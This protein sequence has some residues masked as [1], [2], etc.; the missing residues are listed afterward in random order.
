MTTRKAQKIEDLV[1]DEISL[2]DKGANQHAVVTI[3]K[4]A[5][6]EMEEAMEIYDEQ[7]NPLDL[8]AL[9]DGDVVYD[10]NGE[11]YQFTLDDEDGVEEVE[12]VREPELVGKSF[13]NPFRRQPVA[14]AK[15]GDFAA[16]LREEL[17]K[18]LTDRDR[19]AVISKAFGTIEVLSSQVSKAQAA[20]ET[21]RRIRLER[22]YTEIAKS[23]NLPI[24]DDVLGGVLLRCAENLSFED[25]EII[26][27]AFEAAGEAHLME[28]G[29]VGGGDNS[30]ILNQ[31]NAFAKEA[32]SKSA[33]LSY[34]DV[35]SEI[36]EKNPELYDQYLSEKY[37]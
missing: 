14:K 3:A 13:D 12:E 25:C 31:V 29:N 16:N 1:I 17:S 8:D 22:E 6:G 7:G 19:D 9:N 34:A 20:A 10:A 11:A 33:G 4:S 5:S 32:V 18:A 36:F 27:K 26:S 15:G 23:Y 35:A 37:N 28:I 24:Q 21:E 2:V 30:D